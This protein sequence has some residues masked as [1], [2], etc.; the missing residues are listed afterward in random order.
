MYFV[1]LNYDY[2]RGVTP[3]AVA[4]ASLCYVIQASEAYHDIEVR[5]T[6]LHGLHEKT[7]LMR[8]SEA[9]LQVFHSELQLYQLVNS[10]PCFSA[11]PTDHQDGENQLTMMQ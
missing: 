5:D 11:A 2:G 4:L 7:D 8:Q 3:S 6:L 9:L 10:Q 1:G